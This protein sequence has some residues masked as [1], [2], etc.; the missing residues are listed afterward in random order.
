MNKNK[1][2]EILKEITDEL[3]LEKIS[4]AGGYNPGPSMV[5][6]AIMGGSKWSCSWPGDFFSSGNNP[7]PAESGTCTGGYRR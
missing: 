6:G 4:G 7:F 1:H 3:D 5:W 2:S